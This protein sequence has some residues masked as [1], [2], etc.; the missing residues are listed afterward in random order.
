MHTE[1]I[2]ID[3]CPYRHIVKHI[4]KVLPNKCIVVF[5]LTFHIKTI[6]LSYSFCFMVPS[7]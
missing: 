1:N 7:D 5:S 3:E 2:I 4:S 6:I